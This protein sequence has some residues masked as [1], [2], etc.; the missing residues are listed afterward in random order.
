MVVVKREG[1]GDE[2]AFGTVECSVER[3][4]PSWSF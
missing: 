2:L 4:E 3:E 1:G